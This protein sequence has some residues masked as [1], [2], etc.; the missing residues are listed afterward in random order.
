MKNRIYKK[1]IYILLFIGLLIHLPT[2]TQAQFKNKWINIGSL[3]NW[4]SEVGCE[5]E[6]GFVA[7]QQYGLQW[8]ALLYRQDSQA[9]KGLWLGVED[10]TD[11]RG[12][13]YPHKVVHAGPRVNGGGEFFPVR[14]DLVSRFEPPLVFVDGVQTFEKVVENDLVDESM[15]ADRMLINVTNTQIGVTMTRKIM[16]FDQQFHDNYMVYEYTF[17]NTGNIDADEEIEFPNKTL[18]GFYAFFQYRYASCRQTRN[19]IGNG[20]GWG[21]NTMIDSRGD[22]PVNPGLYGDPA[23]EGFR[24]QFAWHGYFQDKTVDYDNIGGPIWTPYAGYTADND[25]I[26]R[27]GAPQFVG[28]TT[29]Y[30]DDPNNIGSDSPDQPSTT[31]Y[32]GSDLPET[33]GDRTAYDI[34]GMASEYGWMSRG[35]MTPRHAW[36]VQPDGNFA[37]QTN[38]ANIDPGIPGGFSIGNGYG[39]YTLGPGDSIVIVMAEGAS[40]LGIE[41]CIDVGRDYKQGVID[42]KTKNEFVLSGKDSLFQTFRR[43]IQ[44]FDDGYNFPKP[45]KPPAVFSVDGGGDRISLTWEVYG[46]DANLQGF[47]IY[48]YTG[49]YNNPMNPPTLIYEAGPNDRSYADLTPVRGV[50]YYYYIEA[51][52]QTIAADPALGIPATTLTSS[53]YYTQTY[54]P[55]FLKRPP[56]NNIKDFKIVPNPYIITSSSDRLRFSGEPNKLAFFNIPGQCTIKIYTEVGELINTIE[57]T[58]GSGDEYWKAVTSSNQVVVSGVY[59]AVVTDNETG[60]QAIKKFVIIR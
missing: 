30:A 11:E 27:I 40:G 7:S 49:E 34:L 21:M 28:V 53:H 55:A 20:S 9:A 38:G 44:S 58:D 42:A 45:P 59:I 22:G 4:F 35:H 19:V 25:S 46:S 18:D 2:S 41:M 36:K 15:E 24:A 29:L 54:D 43:A 60:E 32:Y 8:P 12:D 1:E 5:I 14:F 3:H 37:E 33:G 31:G 6:H 13:Y 16:A 56:E 47:R 26:G 17:K 50:G 23:D 48:R 39:P 52:G 57:H 51:V 10:F